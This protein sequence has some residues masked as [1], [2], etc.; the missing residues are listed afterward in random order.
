MI[1]RTFH[2]KEG[3]HSYSVKNINSQTNID[4]MIAKS[5]FLKHQRPTSN[6]TSCPKIKDK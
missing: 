5:H 6:E 3:R 2:L 1:Q 4:A